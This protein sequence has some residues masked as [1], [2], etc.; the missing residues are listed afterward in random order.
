MALDFN[1]NWESNQESDLEKYSSDIKRERRAKLDKQI[2]DKLNKAERE[3]NAL[4]KL[5][6]DDF[7]EVLKRYY[8]N[9]LQEKIKGKPIEDFTKKELIET[10]YQDRIWS[11]YNTAGIVKDV[12]QVLTK[13][14]AY[15]HDWAEITQ[16]Y[17]DLP[18]FG[19]ETIGFGRWAKDFV[20]ALIADPINLLSVGTGKI[21]AREASK[22]ILTQLTKEEFTS[23]VSRKAALEIG[24]KEGALGA[25]VGAGAD[26][27]RQT[28]EIDANLMSDYNVTR[29]LVS[30]AAG[31][32]AQGTIGAA[33]SAWSAKGKAGKFYDKG[34]GFKSDY[35]R[36]FGFAGS[37]AEITYTG[38]SGKVQQVKNKISSKNEPSI[39]EDRT[40]EVP[41]LEK[42]SQ[43]IKRKTPIINL[44]KIKAD[45]PHNAIVKEVVDSINTLIKEGKVR[46]TQRVGLFEDIKAKAAKLLTEENADLLNKEL[47]AI[48]KMA[49]NLAPTVYAGRMNWLLKSKEIGELRKLADNAVDVEEK[50]VVT[51]QL[52]KAIKEKNVLIK[53]HVD[54]V[55]AAS[56]VMNQQKLIVELTP[57][58][59][60]RMETDKILV[61]EVNSTLEK[62]NKMSNSEKIQVINNIAELSSKNDYKM[63][64]A[65]QQA[66]I[67]NKEKNVTFFEALN[68]YTTANLL[69]DPTTHEI[70]ILST[71]IMYQKQV[72]EQYMGG[73][74][75]LIKGN[76]QQG[77][78]QFLMAND[79]FMG[80][81]RFW[82]IALKKAKLSWKA[83]RSIGDAAEHRFDGR[84]ERNMETYL[85][86][87]QTSDDT[88][89]RLLGTVASP[90]GKLSFLSLR[91]LGAGDTFTKNAIHRAAR[92]ANVNQRMR[93]FYPQLWKQQGKFNKADIV[94]LQDEILDVKQNIRFEEA[95]DKIN[96]KKL[97]DL[98]EKLTTLENQKVKQT[99]FEEKWSELYYQYEDE[100]G[101]FRETRTFNSNEAS[102]LDDLTKSV[103]NDPTYVS[104]AS[105]FTQNLRNE[106]LEANQ[107]FPEQQRSDF[108][109]GQMML[110]FANK[111]PAT[112][113][114]TSVHFVKTP[115]NLFK[116]AW[117]MTPVA[118]R[119]NK[120]FQALLKASD[121]V[122]RNKA[123]AI[124]GV[125]QVTFGFAFGLAFFTDR[126]TGSN[127]K[128]PK[129]R[130]SYITYNED[131]TKNYTNLSRFFPLSVPFMI[132]ADVRQAVEKLNNI[133]DDPLYS[134]EQERIVD[135]L[136]YVT[137][138]AF[139]LWSNIFASNLMTKD[140]FEL[141]QMFSETNVTREEGEQSI[142]KLEKYF[143]RST[144]KL[145]PAATGW[146]WTNKVFADS[147]AELMT[148]TDHIKHSTPYGLTKIINE[149]Y[150]GGQY[151]ILNYA[152]ALSPKRDPLG[153][154]YPKSQGL[155]LGNFQDVFPTTA[156]WSKNMLDNNGEKIELSKQALEKIQSLNIQ[157]E[158]PAALIDIGRLKPINLKENI[159]LS[160]KD[161]VDGSKID[162]P[163]GTTLYE[164]MMIVK[165]KIQL[166]GKNLNE[167]IRD[168]LENPNS[169]YNTMYY[170]NR[171]IAGKYEGDQYILD[172]IREFE[173]ASR[174]FV[175]EYAKFEMDGKNTTINLLKQ[176]SEKTIES[177]YKQKQ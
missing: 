69:F 17:A 145:I 71:A 142:S 38:K 22:K 116:T 72:L 173:R 81:F 78:N 35:N 100:F 25:S 7:E 121:P 61:D 165:S 20:P 41:T 130:Y 118:W 159:V 139:S 150:L 175:K 49:P 11:E 109:V 31:G 1:I 102:T 80:Q 48:S 96:V 66:K 64:K 105:S 169:I 93:A 174:D 3:K 99:P 138:S 23:Q 77:I 47:K 58:D 82:Q 13:S 98:N 87:L 60:L 27:A 88:T 28:A 148:M 68:E 86:Q 155:I 59:K 42:T 85:K 124:K 101:N 164:A 91:L 46:T 162:F 40:S 45:E 56:D 50:L 73:L 12:G 160:M 137:G 123:E 115:V 53:N 146:R 70:N 34:D 57:A 140:F 83:N 108:N 134:A 54:T 112:R 156:H 65:I 44:D 153:N 32:V 157:W 106:M 149:K 90:M 133:W 168:E 4:E 104:R 94:K 76:R 84:Q 43:S 67:K 132:A 163:E 107:F 126:L 110:D 24:L 125:G 5:Q 129:H 147:E 176:S 127:E 95:A 120:E 119:L 15:K 141:T 167:T 152:D 151:E 158:R 117:Q 52:I 8:K 135:F 51:N 136:S 9:G 14:E 26:F 97:K 113:I 16:V 19:S 122:V 114:L 29:T 154:I 21:V 166:G 103:A 39:I 177:I 92:V 111:H 144:S 161:P 18:Y 36:D 172:K 37:E 10:F 33:M 143:G 55:Q 6:S 2:Y 89:S 128:D 79:L 63:L 171:L 62:I 74:I 75:N 131:G 30:S 170:K